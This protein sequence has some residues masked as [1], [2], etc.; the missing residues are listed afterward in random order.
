M[1]VVSHMGTSLMNPIK[2]PTKEGPRDPA[3]EGPRVP[4]KTKDVIGADLQS[5]EFKK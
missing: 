5:P 3:K 1:C 2:D 4:T